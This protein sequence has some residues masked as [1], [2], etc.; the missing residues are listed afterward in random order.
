M[1]TL[2]A[3]GGSPI[4]TYASFFYMAAITAHISHRPWN[5]T[6]LKRF[7]GFAVRAF[8]GDKIRKNK[9][10]DEKTTWKEAESI[11][12]FKIKSEPYKQSYESYEI[13]E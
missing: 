6:P 11:S 7:N 5:R 4:I 13:G 3:A 10:K 1:K 2:G 12:V 9:W 8:G